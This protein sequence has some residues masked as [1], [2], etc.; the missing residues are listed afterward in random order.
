[1]MAPDIYNLQRF[2]DAQRAS[3]TRVVKELAGGRKQSHWMWYIFPQIQGL[4]RSAMSRK[5][6]IASLQ[7]AAAYLDHP[8]LGA[9]LRECTQLVTAVKLSPIQDILGHP[10]DLKFHSSMTLFA[11]ATADNQI[12][13]DALKKFFRGGFDDAA[14][15]R[16][17][18]L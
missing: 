2:I 6:A 3:Y 15:A 17:L 8:I 1:M 16:A 4:G 11:H 14:L 13:L 5:Y 9:R 18:Q 10:D 12:F 7:E